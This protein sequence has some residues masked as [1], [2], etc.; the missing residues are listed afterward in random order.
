MMQITLFETDQELGEK[1]LS[2]KWGT[3]EW[4]KGVAFPKVNTIQSWE[5]R[6]KMLT[7]NDNQDLLHP[8]KYVKQQFICSCVRPVGSM[9]L[10]KFKSS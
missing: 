10:K 2:R 9:D 1:Y 3:Y 4:T 6:Q 5:H 8:N 7:Q